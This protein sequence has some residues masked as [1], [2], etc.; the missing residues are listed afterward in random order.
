MVSNWITAYKYKVALFG[1]QQKSPY[2]QNTQKLKTLEINSQNT[3]DI[4]SAGEN[5]KVPTYLV[6]IKKF[7]NKKAALP[8]QTE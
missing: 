2:E 7:T 4:P 8:T 1:W 3:V 5:Y 6:G